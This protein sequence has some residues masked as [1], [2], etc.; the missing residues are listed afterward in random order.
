MTISRKDIEKVAVLARIQ[1]DDAQ[2]SALEKDL[3]NILDLVD[4]LSAA[5]TESVEPLAHPLD[6]VQRLRPDEVTETDQ[7]AEFQAIAPATEN[8][9]YLVPR[10]IE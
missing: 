1:V 5:D 3:G 10:V 7:R 2:V 4:Q 8:G 9:L 6:A